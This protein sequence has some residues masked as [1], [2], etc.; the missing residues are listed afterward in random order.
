MQSLGVL[1]GVAQVLEAS[2]RLG[3]LVAALE[4]QRP[5]A[6]EED[7]ELASPRAGEEAVEPGVAGR[8]PL[9]RARPAL[10]TRVG[11]GVVRRAGRGAAGFSAGFSFAGRAGRGSAGF[12]AGFSAAGF[13]AGGRSRVASPVAAAG[14]FAPLPDSQW[15]VPSERCSILM[16][17]P[18]LSSLSVTFTCCTP[19]FM[20]NLPEL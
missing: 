15:T 1:L 12:S 4:E 18:V 13:S 20:V 5:R 7:L 9:E 14:L 10:A 8:L 19:H 11:G 2:Q 3:G 17:S 6:I 16:V